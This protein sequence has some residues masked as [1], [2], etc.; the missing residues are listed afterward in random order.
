MKERMLGQ[1]QKRA[2]NLAALKIRE[3]LSMCLRLWFCWAHESAPN[4]DASYRTDDRDRDPK[5]VVA[6]CRMRSLRI[7]T[8]PW[9]FGFNFQPVRAAGIQ[10][11]DFVAHGDFKGPTCTG[12][13]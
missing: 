12:Q 3:F 9:V 5:E 13:N 7:R 4:N 6:R 8:R 2:A 11:F 10:G 1:A